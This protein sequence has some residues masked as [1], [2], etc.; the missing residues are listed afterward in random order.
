[1]AGR[2]LNRRPA[3]DKLNRQIQRGLVM[4]RITYLAAIAAGILALVAPALAA[5]ESFTGSVKAVSGSSITVERGTLTGVFIVTGNTQVK[6]HGAAAKTKEARAAGKAGLT[7]PDAVHVGD[8][9]TVRYLEQGS[10]LVASDISV[11][12]SLAR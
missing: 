4:K 3:T 5:S 1:M 11:R 10:G 9:V 2:L 7:I 8:Q 12:A 6:V